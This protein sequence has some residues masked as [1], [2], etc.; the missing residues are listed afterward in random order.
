MIDEG[1][2]PKKDRSPAQMRDDRIFNGAIKGGKVQQ[3]MIKSGY[4]PR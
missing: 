3:N 1:Y 4:I 2:I